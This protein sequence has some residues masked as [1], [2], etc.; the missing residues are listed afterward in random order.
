MSALAQALAK[1]GI[2]D[3][4]KAANINTERE[5][6][7]KKYKHL[8]SQI[9]LKI[10]E[11]RKILAMRDSVIK[12][13]KQKSVDSIKDAQTIQNILFFL[14]LKFLNFAAAANQRFVLST[15]QTQ[16]TEIENTMKPMIICCKKLEKEWGFKRNVPARK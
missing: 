1:A 6:A 10:A 13:G 12:L 8:S 3:K 14:G 2:V 4:E 15:F 9:L 16:L 11:K 7:L 5:E